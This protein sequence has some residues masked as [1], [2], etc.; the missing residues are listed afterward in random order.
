MT[1]PVALTVPVTTTPVL[2]TVSTLA[3][4]AL[5]IVT[6]AFEYTATLLVP[7]DIEFAE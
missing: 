3:V 2:D 6:L 4:P 5:L 1:L 7:P